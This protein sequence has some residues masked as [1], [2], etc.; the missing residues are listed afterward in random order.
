[1]RQSI[2]GY[3]DGVLALSSASADRGR[4]EWTELASELEAVN[5]VVSGSED[6]SRALKDAHVPLASRR[7]LLTDLFGGRVGERTLRLL[8]YILQADRASD[9]VDDFV[10]LAERIDAARRDMVPVGDVVLGAKGAEERAEGFTS[11]ILDTVS[12]PRELSDIEDDLFRFSR[13]VA[14]SPE[15]RAAMSD[16]DLPVEARAGLVHDLLAGKAR[17]ASLLLATYLTKVGRPRDFEQLLGAVIDRV[18]SESNRRLADVRS[19]LPLDEAQERELAGALG[20][21]IGH[22]VDIRVTVDPS[23]L[24]GFVATI[25]DTVVDG[26]ARHRLDLLK[27]RLVLP[28]ADITTGERH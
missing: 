26:S 24:A 13:I 18:A 28:E 12:D 4:S 10:W 15:L 6:L 27:E 5:A 21:L 19:A 16:R 22:D 9:T 3:T 11:A 23:V 1:M 8:N 20:R 14:G 25:G 2:R 7:G 17:T